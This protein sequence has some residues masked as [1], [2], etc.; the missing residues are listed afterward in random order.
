M[1]SSGTHFHG[2]EGRKGRVG[3]TTKFGYEEIIDVLPMPGTPTTENTIMEN[4]SR[5]CAEI[6]AL[7]VVSYAGVWV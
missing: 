5:H 4:L 1:P 2:C 6:M 3:R 7:H